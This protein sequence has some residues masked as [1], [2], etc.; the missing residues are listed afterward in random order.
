MHWTI[1]L[2]SIVPD[3]EGIVLVRARG[4]D[5][6]SSGRRGPFDDTPAAPPDGGE[7]D[8]PAAPPDG[9]NDTPAA[10]AGEVDAPAAPAA[11]AAAAAELPAPVCW[12]FCANQKSR[13]KARK[14]DSS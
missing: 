2:E 9:W 3:L 6:A 13:V 4:A 8:T 10:P 14:N 12:L 5:T 1:F 7:E 11:A